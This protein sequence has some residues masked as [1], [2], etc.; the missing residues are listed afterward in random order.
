MAKKKTAKSAPKASVSKAR[1]VVSTGGKTKPKRATKKD[2]FEQRTEIKLGNLT[3]EIPKSQSPGNYQLSLTH[4]NGNPVKVKGDKS[5]GQYKDFLRFNQD[6]STTPNAVYSLKGVAVE[7]YET[8]QPLGG[9]S[10]KLTI[11]IKAV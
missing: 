3:L 1:K 2:T 11:T 4:A 8:I 10:G 9:G 7:D 6:I 5:G